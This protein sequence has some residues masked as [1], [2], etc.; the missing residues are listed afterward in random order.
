[1][2]AAQGGAD[3]RKFLRVVFSVLT[4]IARCVIMVSEV[5]KD[6][7]EETTGTTTS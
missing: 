5:L 6:D 7:T 1:M 3:M 4:K 2:Q